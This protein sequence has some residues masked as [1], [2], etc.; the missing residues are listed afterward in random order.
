MLSVLSRPLALLDSDV[1][2]LLWGALSPSPFSR[3]VTTRPR[4]LAPFSLL[5]CNLMQHGFDSLPK[6]EEHDDKYE[7]R[8]ETPGIRKDE[9]EVELVGRRSLVVS[10][11]AQ[12]KTT[13]DSSTSHQNNG[14]HD[15]QAQSE[16]NSLQQ[17]DSN[18]SFKVRKTI[19]LPKNADIESIKM[20]YADGV[21]RIEAAKRPAD[22]TEEAD[23][24]T[25]AMETELKRKRERYETL[26]RELEDERE[27]VVE[28]EAQLRQAKVAKRQKIASERRQLTVTH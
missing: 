6:L 20:S 5:S 17:Q 22:H 14:S 13:S 1:D 10:A 4:T 9:L 25:A 19:M 2:D 27:R 12:A 8:V 23:E 7:I 11:R 3:V 18:A 28:A 26:Q 15:A 16:N 21:L 24:E